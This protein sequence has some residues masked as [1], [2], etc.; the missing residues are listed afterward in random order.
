LPGYLARLALDLASFILYTLNLAAPSLS[1]RDAFSGVMITNVG[2]FGIERAFVPFAPYS[3]VSLVVAMGRA[4]PRPVVE[5]GEVRAARTMRL[6]F[7]C[8]HRLV[9]GFHIGRL[10]ASIRTCF[11]EPERLITMEQAP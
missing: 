10:L 1:P 11:E 4:A 5:N 2:T 6:G 3:R 7:T 8:D 9:D